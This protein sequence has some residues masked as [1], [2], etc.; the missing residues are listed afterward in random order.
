MAIAFVHEDG[1]GLPNATSLA[2]E[3]EANEYFENIG[4]KDQWT[5]FTANQRRGALN[6]ASRF[7]DDVY[8]ERYL[9]NL[10]ETTKDSQALLWPRENVPNDRGGFY[11]GLGT[12]LPAPLHRA[13]S[14]FALAYLETGSL[15]GANQD[16]GPVVTESAVE[17]VGAVK[18]AEK[19]AGGGN[20]SSFRSFPQAQRHLA[21]LLLPAQ[22]RVLRA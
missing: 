1:S 20:V 19:F 15:Y 4:Q 9:G 16:Q 18:K 3:T 7:V 14:E 13:V 2:S 10:P 21:P 12:E 8:G 17:V 11:L 6:Y 22:S 5:A